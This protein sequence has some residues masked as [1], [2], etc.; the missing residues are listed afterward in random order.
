MDL[1]AGVGQVQ[2]EKMMLHTCTK[3]SEDVRAVGLVCLYLFHVP[4]TCLNY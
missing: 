3:S 2:S 1:G 4:N